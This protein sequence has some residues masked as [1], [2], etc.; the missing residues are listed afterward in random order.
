[1]TTIDQLIT[2]SFDNRGTSTNTKTRGEY[3]R[4]VHALIDNTNA[5]KYLHTNITVL[6]TY[7][8]VMTRLRQVV[9]QWEE[10]TL[11][12]V[13]RHRPVKESGK[14]PTKQAN[15]STCVQLDPVYPPT[16][17]APPPYGTTEA[18]TDIYDLYQWVMQQRCANIPEI[19]RIGGIDRI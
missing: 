6:T 2:E 12:R 13:H 7:E 3:R 9:K 16:E 15:Y 10:V 5:Y 1:M 14:L 18:A 19:P 17:Y 4:A 8:Y 11:K